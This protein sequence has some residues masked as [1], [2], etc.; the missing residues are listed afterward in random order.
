MKMEARNDSEI[1]N[2]SIYIKKKR[3]IQSQSTTDCGDIRIER[4][5][6]KHQTFYK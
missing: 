2:I 4:F 3:Q 6:A 1:Y 5:E